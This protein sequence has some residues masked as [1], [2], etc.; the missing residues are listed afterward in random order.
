MRPPK[1]D[2]T[3]V[4]VIRDADLRAL[5]EACAGRSF[6][7]RRDTALLRLFMSTGTRLSEIAELTLDDA[8]RAPIQRAL[9]CLSS[10][11]V[12]DRPAAVGDA[13]G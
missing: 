3:P 7:D 8:D 11:V 12:S 9:S 2:E 1:L 4:P 13:Q 5:L 10:A 6:D